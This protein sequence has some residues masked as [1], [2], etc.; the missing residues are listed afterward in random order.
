MCDGFIV[1][2]RSE[3]GVQCSH[4]KAL[5][6]FSF[7]LLLW[8]SGVILWRNRNSPEIGHVTVHMLSKLEASAPPQPVWS[9]LPQPWLSHS[10]QQHT[11]TPWEQN[12]TPGWAVLATCCVL[13]HRSFSGDWCLLKLFV[14]PPVAT[15]TLHTW[16]AEQECWMLSGC[17]P[18]DKPY[19]FG[20]LDSAVYPNSRCVAFLRTIRCHR[21]SLFS[22]YDV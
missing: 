4:S 2:L 20:K 3:F 17:L 18:E 15:V 9:W 11:L 8:V 10:S 16:A 19:Y 22:S 5:L 14:F 21:L 13:G 6:P 7:C 1:A 12:A